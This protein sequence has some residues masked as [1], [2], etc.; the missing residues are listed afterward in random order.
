M[1]RGKHYRIRI[2]NAGTQQYL[3][4]CFE[5]HKVSLLAAD[6]TPLDQPEMPNGCVDIN[7]GQR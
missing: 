7:S 2:M 4:V 3:T 5:R 1:Q 6:T